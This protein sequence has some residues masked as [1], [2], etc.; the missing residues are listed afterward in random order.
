M[1]ITK[2]LNYECLN[3]INNALNSTNNNSLNITRD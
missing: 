1:K 2:N 3:N